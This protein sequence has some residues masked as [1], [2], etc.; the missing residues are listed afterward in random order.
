[1]LVQLILTTAAAQLLM[2]A[3]TLNHSKYENVPDGCACYQASIV[4]KLEKCERHPTGPTN[5]YE[6]TVDVALRRSNTHRIEGLV[7]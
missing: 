7:L 1:M 2:K 5:I 4:L 3:H 6:N